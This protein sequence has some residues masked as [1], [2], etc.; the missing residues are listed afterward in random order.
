MLLK[1]KANAAVSISFIA[2]IVSEWNKSS[3]EKD[4]KPMWILNKN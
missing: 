1:K 2:A 3:G 4:N